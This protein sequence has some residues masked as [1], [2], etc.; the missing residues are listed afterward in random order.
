M[1]WFSFVRGKIPLSDNNLSNA[2]RQGVLPIFSTIG[3][4]QFTVAMPLR[5]LQTPQVF[6]NAAV[7]MA[8]IGGL[9]AG[10]LVL[11]SL[12]QNQNPNQ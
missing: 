2:K 6:I 12:T 8:G 7:P 5:A 10:K 9:I 4:P 3:F 11:Q 1:S